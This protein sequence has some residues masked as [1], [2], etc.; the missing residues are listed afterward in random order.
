MLKNKQRYALAYRCLE[1]VFGLFAFAF[2]CSF[3]FLFTLNARLLVMFSFSELCENSASSTLLFKSAKSAI[4]SFVFFYS[5]FC[6]LVHP[7]HSN[8]AKVSL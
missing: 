1:T 2:S 3:R 6:H 5:D 4:Q 8:K 7:L